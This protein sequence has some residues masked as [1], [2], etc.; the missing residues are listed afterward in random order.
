MK[1]QNIVFIL[2]VV[3]GLNS[4]QCADLKPLVPVGQTV[5]N[6]VPSAPAAT[7]GNPS[8]VQTSSG[9]APTATASSDQKSS[10]TQTAA[11]KAGVKDSDLQGATHSKRTLKFFNDTKENAVWAACDVWVGPIP[12][13]C[14]A[15]GIAYAAESEKGLTVHVDAY[16][17]DGSVYLPHDKIQNTKNEFTDNQ[18]IVEGDVYIKHIKLGYKNYETVTFNATG[19]YKGKNRA[20]VD[21]V[22]H[23]NLNERSAGWGYWEI[24]I[25]KELQTAKAGDTEEV[26][27]MR[28]YHIYD[29]H[30]KGLL[31]EKEMKQEKT[32]VCRKISYKK[33]S[34]LKKD[35]QE[36]AKKKK[37]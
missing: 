6:S 18:I 16:K 4:T 14:V 7:S 27:V 8:V 30:Y 34:K 21:I 19:S 29:K 26:L 3:V 2:M 20:A 24:Y 36:A 17:K 5:D 9:T 1:K 10:T 35:K 12:V 32:L 37:K 13:G 15:G 22:E 23:Y 31:G 28:L 11:Q 33:G 25:H